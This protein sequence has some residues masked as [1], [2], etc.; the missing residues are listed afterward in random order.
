MKGGNGGDGA[1]G[2]RQEWNSG[3]RYNSAIAE[4][5]QPQPIARA[6][7]TR[8]DFS[9]KG[10]RTAAARPGSGG[11]CGCAAALGNALR[12]GANQQGDV[13]GMTECRGDD[14]CKCR[15]LRAGAVHRAAG[16]DPYVRRTGMGEVAQLVI[17][18]TLLCRQQQ[19]Q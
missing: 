15:T 2:C 3:H 4:R 13:E 8:P 19:Q 5:M 16:I 1:Q 17:N 18:G 11:V 7:T 12:R 9:A 10:G 6:T 14:L